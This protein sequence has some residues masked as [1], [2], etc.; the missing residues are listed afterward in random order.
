MLPRTNLSL[1]NVIIFLIYWFIE[2]YNL[3]KEVEEIIMFD[4]F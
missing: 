1:K 4:K 3:S 2:T